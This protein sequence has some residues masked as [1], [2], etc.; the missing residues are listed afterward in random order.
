MQENHRCSDPKANSD[1]AETATAPSFAR[2]LRAYNLGETDDDED[3][4]EL[5]GEPST[6]APKF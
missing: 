1:G 6:L 2:R 3:Y 4:R 5:A